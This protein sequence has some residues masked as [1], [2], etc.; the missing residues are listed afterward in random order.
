MRVCC[1]RG[2]LGF[3]GARSAVL[4][5]KGT[6]GG[7]PPPGPGLARRYKWGCHRM[8]L[9]SRYAVPRL[10]WLGAT[11]AALQHADPGAFQAGFIF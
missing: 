3:W 2:W 8:E 4:L 9:G 11:S 1:G 7:C 6:T 10:L 5:A